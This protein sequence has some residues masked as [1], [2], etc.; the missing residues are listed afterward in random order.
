VLGLFDLVAIPLIAIL[1]VLVVRSGAGLPE[2]LP[3]LACDELDTAEFTPTKFELGLGGELE[4]DTLFASN[5]EYLIQS[6]LV[7]P[8]NRR[9]LVQPGARLEFEEEAGIDVQ[10]ALYVCGTE[11]EP[12]TL[13]AETGEPGSWQGIR[14]L[15]ADDSS[16]LAHTLLQFA[17][18]RAIHLENSAPTL[19]DVKIASSSAFPISSDGSKMP[20]L[21]DGVEFDK[22]PFEGIEI[23]GG[24]TADTQNITWPE[25]GFVYVVS[26]PVTIGENSTLTI[27]PGTTV[28]FWYDGRNEQP[29]L[30]VRGLLKAEDVRFT[31]VYDGR[32]EVGGVTYKEARDPQAGDWAGLSFDNSSSQ[33]FLRNALVQFAGN[34]Q[35]AIS[36]QNSSPELSNVTIADSAW[37]P[38]SADADSFP[39]LNQISLL[40]NDPGDALE[41]RGGSAVSGRQRYTW[42]K[43]GDGAQ[44]VR[45]I[46]GD[47]T[48]EPEATLVIEPGVVIKFEPQSSLTIEG[49]LEAVGGENEDE[50]II[51][52]SVRDD[53]YGGAT[54][55]NTGPQDSRS[56][57][58][59]LFQQSDESSILENALVRYGSIAFEAAAPRLQNVT[60]QESESAALWATPDA[61]PSLSN[62]Q[63]QDN[64]TNGLAIA[65]G[66][67]N[68]DQ[69]WTAVSNGDQPLVRILS[70]GLT[71]AEGATLQIQPGVIVKADEDGR[72]VIN[73]GLQARGDGSQPIIFT[74][75]HD[76]SAGGD[77]NQQLQEANAG[78]WPGLEIG[79]QADVTLA[80][81][82]IRF[83]RDG[84]FLRGGNG[85]TAN[86]LLQL[87]DGVNAVR[88]DGESDLPS[89]ILAEGNEVNELEC[90]NP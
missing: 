40:D 60:I 85:L 69:T 23:R 14:F 61:S 52:T 6:V 64:A 2:P 33:S 36:L 47:V 58:G 10:G 12:V 82:T 28:K 57:D 77:T 38:L 44:I 29:G 22:N 74:S 84:L 34:G 65:A 42:G 89:T 16:M 54:D 13:T 18:D 4:E 15:E 27:E 19:L 37:Y 88:C 31:S 59:L 25:Q 79:A 26:G 63:L 48:V 11:K 71:V 80:D 55:K 1:A 51:F 90:P 70:G 46:R 7:V 53:E 32:D 3:P 45:V 86:G 49:T 62:I 24:Q 68:V 56:W 41:V 76:D 50:R 83:A 8:Q 30:L 78:D 35:G 20:L 73:G 39:T 9:L 21:L 81:A 67:L 43:L 17:G 75:L 87:L 5:A 72:L 66:T